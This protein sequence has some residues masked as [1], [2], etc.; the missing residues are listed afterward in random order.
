MKVGFISLEM[1]KKLILKRFYELKNTFF[2]DD[3]FESLKQIDL[4]S[5]NLLLEAPKSNKISELAKTIKVMKDNKVE[6]VYIDYIGL[7]SAEDSYIPK[8]DQVS[9][10]S[11]KLKEL[12]KL[13]Q[14]PI[15]VIS[16]LN[17]SAEKEAPTLA[18]IRD[19]G[20]IEEDA[21]IIFF[22][23]RDRSGNFDNNAY[24]HL[25]KNRNGRV[26]EKIRFSFL[27]NKT[28]FIEKDE[29]IFYE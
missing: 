18:D 16:Q 9:K 22:L 7:I 4:F 26:V 29:V 20:A 21:D 27:A 24:L 5:K 6:I 19:S 10:I 17:R 25:A 3:L 15:V 14:I 2:I 13:Y 28:R 11:K 23:N 12:S 8:R 1:S